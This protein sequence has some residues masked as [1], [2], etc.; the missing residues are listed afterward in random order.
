MKGYQVFYLFLI[1]L[2]TFSVFCFIESKCIILYLFLKI[3]RNTKKS[4]VPN[5]IQYLQNLS[6]T[7]CVPCLCGF[8][9][10]KIYIRSTLL[11]SYHY[12]TGNVTVSLQQ[13]IFRGL[14]CYCNLI[15]N[16]IF[17]QS[18]FLVKIILQRIY[19]CIIGKLTL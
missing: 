3:Y 19:V 15:A 16:L 6:S 5:I 11:K 1:N 8:T 9:T 7:F 12:L 2:P 17:M 4:H 10:I 13:P 18:N 14:F